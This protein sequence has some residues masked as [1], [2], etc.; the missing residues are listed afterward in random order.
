[1]LLLNVQFVFAVKF[2]NYFIMY[3]KK[4]IVF[5]VKA[6]LNYYNFGGIFKNKQLLKKYNF[7]YLNKFITL[8]NIKKLHLHKK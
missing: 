3:L 4:K 7:E 5:N 2:N 6:N 8:F 1:M